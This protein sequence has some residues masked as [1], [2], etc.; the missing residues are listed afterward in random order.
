MMSR[1]RGLKSSYR[2]STWVGRNR[3]GSGF[4]EAKGRERS[5]S[6]WALE[7][8]IHG[9]WGATFGFNH[10]EASGDSGGSGGHGSKTKVGREGPG[11]Q[12]WRKEGHQQGSE[13]LEEGRVRDEEVAGGRAGLAR[14]S[15]L[16]V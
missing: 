15:V 10:W 14:F 2:S 12:G 13:S 11:K 5:Q 1:G 8:Q 3:G 16:K 4:T 6:R 7:G 9:R